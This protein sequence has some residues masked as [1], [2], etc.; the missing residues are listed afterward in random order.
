[1]NTENRK[2]L[3]EAFAVFFENPSR[4]SL[5]KLLI[6]HTGEH[7][8]LDFKS[9]LITPP[10]LAKHII[11]M[12][13]KAGGVIV[14]GVKETENGKFESVGIGLNDKT[15]FLR[16]INAYV[17]DKLSYEVIDFN[18]NEIE[19]TEIKGKSFRVVIIEYSPEYIPFLSKK[20][21]EGIKKNLIYI[22]K[23]ASSDMAEYND[24]Q[25][26]FNRRLETSFSSAREISLTEH[27]KELKEIYSLINR[28][29]WYEDFNFPDP[30]PPDD[31]EYVA[32]P[33]YPKEDYADFVVRMLNLKK[34]VIE[35]IIKSDKFFK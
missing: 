5:R 8:D 7:D 15:H 11:A 32:N 34:S 12:A 16:D 9:A 26:I 3:K 17:P 30:P 18:F 1:M 21:G 35:S 33:K 24:L 23:N 2:G 20:D 25:D 4:E 10:I 22:R 31:L 29:W 14:F 27:F 28:G 6:D 13:N 19:Y